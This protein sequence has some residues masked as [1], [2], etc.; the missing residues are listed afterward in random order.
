MMD[1]VKFT[2]AAMRMCN[3]YYS[4]CWSCPAGDSTSCQLDSSYSAISAEEK[5]SIVEQWAERHPAKTRQSVFLE[6]YPEARLSEDGI[7]LICPRMISAEYRDEDD[8][9]NRVNYGTCADCRREF[10]SAEVEE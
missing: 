3:D 8:S 7:L 1:A 5:V 10:W 6:Q 2:R 9:C 4:K